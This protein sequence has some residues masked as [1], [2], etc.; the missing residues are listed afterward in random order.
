MLMEEARIRHELLTADAARIER[1][2]R[3]EDLRRFDRLQRRAAIIGARL[4]LGARAAAS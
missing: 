2:A 3:F 1:L 4:G